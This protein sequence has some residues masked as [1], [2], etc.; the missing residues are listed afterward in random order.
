MTCWKNLKME[1]AGPRVCRLCASYSLMCQRVCN[2]NMFFF[3]LEN[4]VVFSAAVLIT[5]IV[6][7]LSYFV[8]KAKSS[9]LQYFTG[10][11]LHLSN[12]KVFFEWEDPK[13]VGETLA[14]TVRVSL[15]KTSA[16]NMT[17][18]KSF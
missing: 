16:K 9:F 1:I 7:V 15:N 6:G 3:F 18:F 5:F 2:Y 12:C 8:L 14:F 11:Y 17:K 13:M 10:K 4:V